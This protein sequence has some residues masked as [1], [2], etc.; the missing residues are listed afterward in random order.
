MAARSLIVVLLVGL[1][2]LYAGSLQSRQSRAA[3]IPRLEDLPRSLENWVGEDVPISPEVAEVLGADAIV[4]RLYRGP[5]GAQ[6]WMFCAYFRRQ[7]VGSQIHSP[8]HCVPGSGWSV[9]RSKPVRLVL[10][11][12]E[13]AAQRLVMDRE[14]QRQVMIY[15]FRTRSGAVTGEYHLKLDLVRNALRG[16]PTDAAFVR[17]HAPEENE[18]A[19]LDLMQRLEGPLDRV[20]GAVGLP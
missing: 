4:Q 3:A 19:M 1:A 20:L 2:G 14:G 6:V 18:T 7:Q 13:Q 11:G 10:G 15:W 12:R 9:L 17:Y 8:Q 5:K 16:R